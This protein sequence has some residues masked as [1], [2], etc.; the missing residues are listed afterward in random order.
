MKVLVIGAN[1]QLGSDLIKVFQAAGDSV[2]P[3]THAQ[4]D[5]C[6][7]DQVAE[8]MA[9]AKP[10][11]V[12]STAAFHRVEECEQKPELAFQVNGAGALNLARVCQKTGAILVNYSTDY[13]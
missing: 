12:I 4:L 2:V 13:V 3:A 11:L 8:A 1:G 10:D 9:Q 7:E 6:L 5:V